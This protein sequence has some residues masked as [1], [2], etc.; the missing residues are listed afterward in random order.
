MLAA[1]QTHIEAEK[2]FQMFQWNEKAN[3]RI[4]YC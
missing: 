1:L 3:E 2:M 4:L